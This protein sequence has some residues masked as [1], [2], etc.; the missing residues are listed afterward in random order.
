MITFL[1]SEQ[2]PGNQGDKG[3]SSG[4]NGNDPNKNGDDKKLIG[5]GLA[6]IILGYSVITLFSMIFPPANKPDVLRYVSW[7]EFYHQMLSKG[8]VELIVVKPDLD[9]VTIYLYDGAVIRGKNVPFRSYH[10]N[11]VNVPTFEARLRDAERRLG[12]K[13]DQSVQI[14]YE[15]N[16]ENIWFGVISLLVVAAVVSFLLRGSPMGKG[17]L[18]SNLFVSIFA[19]FYMQKLLIGFLL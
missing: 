18:N 7:N 15:R 4:P 12:I 1:L 17:P 19:F 9:L 6:W 5:Y 13:S 2:Q 3:S 16:Q 11:I 10:M 8:E 14:I